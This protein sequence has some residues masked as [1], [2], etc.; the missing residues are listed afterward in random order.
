MSLLPQLLSRSEAWLWGKPISAARI[1]EQPSD[2]CVEEIL[3]FEPDG[4]GEHVFV[5]IQ[6]TGE[7][8]EWVARQLAKFT[9]TNPRDIGY[10]GKKDRHAITQQW[11]SFKHPI[12]A[13]PIRWSLFETST[14]KVL[15][16]T[17]H[18]RKLKT[19]VLQGNR[20]ELLLRNVTEPLA[21]VERF[22]AIQKA[23]VPNY[24]G[25][26]RFG[27]AYGNITQGEALLAGVLKERQSHKRGLYISA[28]RSALFNQ[29]VS[30]RILQHRWETVQIGDV[31]MLPSSQS[32]FVVEQGMSNMAARLAAGELSHTAPMWGAG[33]LM[34][35]GVAADFEKSIVSEWQAWADALETLGLRQERRR[36]RLMPEFA[37]L[38]QVTE[39]QFRVTFSLPAGS[40][41]TSVLRELCLVENSQQVELAE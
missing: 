12:K 27:Q 26:Q 38:N 34:T 11:F 25:E 30:E 7:N 15:Q 33:E 2:F 35:Q 1:R 17:R 21:L 28:L 9:G 36:A 41:A 24:F 20:F 8:T 10:A 22:K 3:G 23:G 14:I 19:G 6:K 31:L 32:C 16:H 18:G 13:P 29:I 40:F 4:E 37:E 39:S 5:L